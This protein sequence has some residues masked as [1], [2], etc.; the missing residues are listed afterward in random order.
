MFSRR[1]TSL[2][3]VLGVLDGQHQPTLLPKIAY[4][5]ILAWMM[6]TSLDV[7]QNSQWKEKGFG[8]DISIPFFHLG[9]LFSN[10]IYI[11]MKSSID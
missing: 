6:N 5:F 2:T 8:H 7:C 11:P 4:E 1:E 10:E 9:F 3:W